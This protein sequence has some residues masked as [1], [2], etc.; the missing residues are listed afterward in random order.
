MNT[1]KIT[2]QDFIALVTAR[3]TSAGKTAQWM[4]VRKTYISLGAELQ[5]SY[6]GRLQDMIPSDGG[7]GTMTAERRLSVYTWSVME[8]CERHS[9][10][11]EQVMAALDVVL[12]PA[13]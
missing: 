7:N 9:R 3:L 2:S 10:T 6:K 13:V 12:T 5:K 4:D 1:M 8:V 11:A